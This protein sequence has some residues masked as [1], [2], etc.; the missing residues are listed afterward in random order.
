[1]IGSS[2]ISGPFGTRLSSIHFDK[3]SVSCILPIFLLND[4]FIAS[5][6]V[7]W[8]CGGAAV[9]RFELIAFFLNDC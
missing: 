7:L 1:M 6:S 4:S 5:P 8:F 2:V 3:K 9:K